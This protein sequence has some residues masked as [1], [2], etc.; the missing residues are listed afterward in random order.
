MADDGPMKLE[1]LT[2]GLNIAFRVAEVS[3]L[4]CVC[5]CAIEA[6][7]TLRQTQASIQAIQKVSEALPG[8]VLSEVDKQMTGLRSDANSQ[9]TATRLIADKQLA[10]LNAT[11]AS[12]LDQTRSGLLGQTDGLVRDARVGILGIQAGVTQDLASINALVSDKDIPGLV[13]DSRFTVARA[14]RVMGHVE[15]MSDSIAA[16]TPKTAQA[17]SGIAQDVHTATSD[18]V[19]PQPLWRKILSGIGLAS[20]IT[21]FL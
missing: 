14:A 11:L 18:F 3:A 20:G 7:K 17:V 15:V 19:K 6:G 12:Q 8:Q 13:R 2:A 4:A 1:N 9:L 16:E 5:V 21:K 10:T